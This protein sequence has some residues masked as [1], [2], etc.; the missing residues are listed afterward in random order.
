M[1]NEISSPPPHMDF[2]GRF[3]DKKDKYLCVVGSRH[4][5]V[6]G[7]DVTRKLIAGLKGYP[8]TIVSGLAVGIDSIAHEAALENGLNTI[9]F[10]GSGLSLSVLY[11]AVKR[12]LALRIVESGGAL[13]SQFGMNQLGDKWTFPNRNRTMAG[14]S[15]ATL[16]IEAAEKSG[17][18]ITTSHAREFGREVFAVPGSIIS[19]LSYGPHSLIRDGA[20]PVYSAEDILQG[21]GFQVIRTDGM[22]SALPNYSE[23]KLE[24]D[25]RT[26]IDH[27]RIEKL[28][29]TGLI[30]KTGFTATKLNLVIS[31]LELLGL[32]KDA[33]GIYRLM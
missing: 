5:S 18:L 26:I 15:H 9:C 6:Y 14:A 11:P 23:M 22:I 10:P 7:E 12:D 27:L 24:P 17:S 28:S 3:P 30:D 1:L 13:Y 29:S 19:D 32:V 21:L 31:E 16:I 20:T 4:N 33:N 25:Q 2:A 8:I